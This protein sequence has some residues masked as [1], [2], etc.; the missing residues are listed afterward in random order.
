[1][2]AADALNHQLASGSTNFADLS[3]AQFESVAS[4]AD[5]DNPVAV[6]MLIPFNTAVN[7]GLGR[8]LRVSRPGALVLVRAP[9]ANRLTQT[10]L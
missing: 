10:V 3:S 4:D 5:T 2:V 6:N 9:V 7:A 1:V 8:G